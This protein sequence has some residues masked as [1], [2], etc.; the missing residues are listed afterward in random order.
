MTLKL[1]GTNGITNASGT[2]ATRPSST[3][4]GQQGY[5][6]DLGYIEVYDGTD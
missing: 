4:A 5:N 3:V 2:V 1:D 6:S